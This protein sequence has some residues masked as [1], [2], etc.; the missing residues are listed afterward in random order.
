M[1]SRPSAS[2]LKRPIQSMPAD[3]RKALTARKL[4][5]AYRSRPAYQRNDYLAWIK[6]AKLAVTR[7]KRLD[8]M[9]DE[10]ERGGKYMNM[11]YRPRRPS[12]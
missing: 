12:R 5:A 7:K 1:P 11:V 8:Q 6:R 2:R 4:V 9:L 10:L 3:V